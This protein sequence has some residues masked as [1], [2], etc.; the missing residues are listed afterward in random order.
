MTDP[1]TLSLPQRI[2]LQVNTDGDPEDRSEPVSEANWG[3][4][5]WHHDSIGGQEVTYVRE[6]LADGFLLLSLLADIRAAAGDGDGRLMQPDLVEHIR[7]LKARADEAAALA[8]DVATLGQ[9][10]RRLVLAIAHAASD[11][12]Y[13]E[14]YT[15]TSRL[16]ETMGPKIDAARTARGE[17]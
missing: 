1:L 8:A 11:P 6:D 14:S 13:A 12:L 4:L 10:L 3:D 17:G 15:E 16:L 9:G 2:W 7:Q 5:T